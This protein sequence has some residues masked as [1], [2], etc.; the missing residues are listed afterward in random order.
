MDYDKDRTRTVL[1]ISIL[2]VIFFVSYYFLLSNYQKREQAK[3]K[4]PDLVDITSINLQ[5][6]KEQKY[7]TNKVEIT[8]IVNIIKNSKH[9]K[10][11]SVNDYPTNA[12]KVI[13]IT[14]IS[15][16][17]NTTIYIYKQ[18]DKYYVEQPYQNINVI[19]ENSYNIIRK[20]FS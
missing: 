10:K 19:T 6:L 11:Q 1:L 3:I 20:T 5:N 16:E 17:N 9:T 7:V 13:T 14:F 18:N 4:I 12:T 2:I 8:K 15:K